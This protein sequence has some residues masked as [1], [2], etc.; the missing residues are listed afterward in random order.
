MIKLSFSLYYF[1]FGFVVV[2]VVVVVVIYW[3]LLCTDELFVFLFKVLIL[4][5]LLNGIYK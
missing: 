1:D 4:F 3:G 2:I 5:V